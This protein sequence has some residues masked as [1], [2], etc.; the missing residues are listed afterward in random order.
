[1][2]SYRD[3]RRNTGHALSEYDEISGRSL[4]ARVCRNEPGLAVS[5]SQANAFVEISS[6]LKDGSVFE[7]PGPILMTLCVFVWHVC[8]IKDISAAM[9]LIIAAVHMRGPATKIVAGDLEV[10]GVRRVLWFSGVQLARVAV[11]IGLGIGGTI[12]LCRTVSL[13]GLLRTTVAL[14]CAYC[15]CVE[16]RMWV[17]ARNALCVQSFSILTI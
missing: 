13:E 5:N 9:Q 2:A 6:Y 12:L 1:M 7:E 16:M 14:K 17:R 10:L 15:D 4:A 8:L 3:W 11:A